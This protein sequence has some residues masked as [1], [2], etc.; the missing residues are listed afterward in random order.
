MSFDFGYPYSNMPT[1]KPENLEKTTIKLWECQRHGTFSL[2]IK[3]KSLQICDTS[4]TVNYL[5]EKW[6]S[7]K[8]VQVGEHEGSRPRLNSE[9]SGVL[10]WIYDWMLLE[11]PIIPCMN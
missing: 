6:M 7:L 5:P 3:L 8:M 1:T 9:A 10:N 2:S 4:Y 11:W